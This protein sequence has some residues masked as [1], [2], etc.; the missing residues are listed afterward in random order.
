M[1]IADRPARPF[2]DPIHLVIPRV[3]LSGLPR[4]TRLAPCAHPRPVYFRRVHPF[5]CGSPVSRCTRHLA[6]LF[7]G[8]RSGFHRRGRFGF[9]PAPGISSGFRG[10]VLGIGFFRAFVPFR[11]GIRRTGFI[12]RRLRL[13]GSE[14]F[15]LVWF[16]RSRAS[17]KS[18]SSLDDNERNASSPNRFR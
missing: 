10:D 4:Q 2:P 9:G 1:R 18:S 12:P 16:K 13:G 14:L 3:G 6:R 15:R 17:F 11:P 8:H 7:P 5:R